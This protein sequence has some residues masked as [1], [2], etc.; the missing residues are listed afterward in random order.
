MDLVRSAVELRGG[1]HASGSG[2]TVEV[3]NVAAGH[4]YPT[5][6]R[7][8]ASDLFWRP[9]ASGVAAATGEDPGEQPWRFLY[10]IRDPYRYEVDIPSTLIM[11]GETR[12]IDLTDAEGHA[13]VEVMLVYKL[14]PFYRDPETGEPL[15]TE[16]VTDP[17]SDSKA[18]HTIVL[19]P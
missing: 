18:V 11:H 4:S 12:K 7:S 15:E 17:L 9:L 5:D 16:T 3:E 19:K 2:W 13:G 10:R 14:T 1:P 8:R 6:E